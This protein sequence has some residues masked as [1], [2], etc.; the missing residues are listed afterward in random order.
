MP[1]TWNALEGYRLRSPWI[2]G[3]FRG[4]L[5]NGLQWIL[6]FRGVRSRKSIQSSLPILMGRGLCSF[7]MD[8]FHWCCG[9]SHAFTTLRIPLFY[10]SSWVLHIFGLHC[11][12]FISFS[13]FTAAIT[14]SCTMHALFVLLVHEF[15]LFSTYCLRI[16]RSM[17]WF[18]FIHAHFR[19]ISLILLMS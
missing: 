18:Y 3:G 6:I 17:P 15:N 16:R 5:V 4:C 12:V 1:C 9:S 19:P 13:H 2:L 11:T 14:S 10:F 8:L 7:F